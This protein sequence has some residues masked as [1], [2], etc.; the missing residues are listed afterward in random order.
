MVLLGYG[1]VC[2]DAFKYQHRLSKIALSLVPLIVL[3]NGFES[4]LF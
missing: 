1:R 4:A 3:G 2:F